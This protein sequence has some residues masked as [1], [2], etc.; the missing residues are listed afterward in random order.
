ME[1]IP[2]VQYTNQENVDDTDDLINAEFNMNF[3]VDL[4]CD[5]KITAATSRNVTSAIASDSPTAALFQ[6]DESAFMPQ[7]V[8]NNAALTT[9][10]A[11]RK[12]FKV[13]LP[14]SSKQKASPSVNKF[15][16]QQ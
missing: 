9:T 5:V 7:S 10:Q 12:K 13:M 2:T 16:P 14:N 1:V 8:L 15:H 3:G 6:L 4:D 11:S